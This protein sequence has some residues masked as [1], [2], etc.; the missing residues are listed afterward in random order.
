MCLMWE[1]LQFIQYL[2]RLGIVG[3]ILHVANG[4]TNNLVNLFIKQSL[5]GSRRLY[6]IVGDIRIDLCRMSHTTIRQSDIVS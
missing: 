1:I 5:L 2:Y 4:S 3:N 6:L